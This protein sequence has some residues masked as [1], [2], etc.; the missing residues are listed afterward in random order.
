M[1]LQTMTI[2]LPTDIY[3]FLELRAKQTRR[4]V[5]DELVEVVA[6]AV[7]EEQTLPN[8]LESALAQMSF[9]NN[10]ALWN[11]AHSHLSSE[12]AIQLEALNLKQQREGLDAE[13]ELIHG[14]LLHQYEHFML[15]RAQATVL[16]KQRGYDVNELVGAG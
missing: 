2:Q 13:D 16:L 12:D 15:V 1:T 6:T 11:A 9:L 10:E 8:D 7:Q 3:R 14:Q 5:R 4:T